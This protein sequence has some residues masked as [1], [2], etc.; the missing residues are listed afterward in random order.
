MIKRAIGNYSIPILIASAGCLFAAL[1]AAEVDP[2]PESEVWERALAGLKLTT[3]KNV[4]S[5]VLNIP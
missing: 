3:A 5:N 4:K 2:H 1:K